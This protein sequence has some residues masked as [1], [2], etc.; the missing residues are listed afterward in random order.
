M[1]NA[2]R[3]NVT[4]LDL[5]LFRG[6]PMHLVLSLPA[7]FVMP[8]LVRWRLYE[9]G[10]DQLASVQPTLTIQGKTIE[11]R[12]ETNGLPE[13]GCTHALTFDNRT[14]LAGPVFVNRQTVSS[15]AVS[16]DQVKITIDEITPVNVQLIS[17]ILDPTGA[18]VNQVR[19]YVHNQLTPA[20]SWVVQ[21]DLNSYPGGIT[22]LD[23]AGSRWEYEIEYLTPNSLRLSF[24]T[25]SFSGKAYI[26]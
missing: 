2:I 1:K 10:G 4:T 11:L 22:V 13:R 5:V 26:S 12:L 15:P 3:Q 20:A 23:S 18:I 21:H 7:D 14:V 25:I 17:T 6:N 19:S 16:S 24:G 9:P 8:G